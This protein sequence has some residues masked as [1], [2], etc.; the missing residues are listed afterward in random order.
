MLSDPIELRRLQALH[1]AAIESV[2]RTEA[3]ISQTRVDTAKERTQYFEKLA[4]GSGATIAAIVSFLGVHSG[5]LQPAWIIRFSLV[6]F[7]AAIIA[8]L[9]RNFRYPFYVL[10]AKQLS[11][12]RAKLHE[13]ECR[14]DYLRADPNVHSWQTGEQ[15]DVPTWISGAEKAVAELQP[16]IAKKEKRTTRL[17]R[18]V[19]ISE[20]ACL[21]S[22]A[23]GM[24]SLALLA[25]LNF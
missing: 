8:A 15:I 17:F 9:Y 11:W 2:S 1:Q 14:K 7:T 13:Q 5:K 20:G 4:I 18:E 12:I 6:V 25:L 23:L 3:D 10:A 19:Q 16:E 21:L 24:I 22:V